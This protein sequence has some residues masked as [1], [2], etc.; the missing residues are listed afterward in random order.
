MT[1]KSLDKKKTNKAEWEDKLDKLKEELLDRVDEF[2]P[3]IKPNGGNKGRGE[4]V[5]LVGLALAGFYK[6]LSS[7][8]QRLIEKID[9]GIEQFSEMI[10]EDLSKTGNW[11]DQQEVEA[12]LQSY[13]D[14]FKLSA[15]RKEGE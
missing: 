14:L 10:W 6:L 8:R 2:F 11:I 13:L 9:K 1:P 4:A 5:V 15:I 7:E 12:S 3:K